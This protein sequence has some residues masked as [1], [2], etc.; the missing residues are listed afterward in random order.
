MEKQDIEELRER[1][2]CAAVLEAAGFALDLRESTR[3]ALKYRRGGEIVIVNHEGRGWFDPLSDAKG[4]VFSL[5]SH[6]DGGSFAQALDRIAEL[7]GF[8]P[9]TPHWR[10][11]AREAEI[12]AALPDRWRSRRKPWPGSA[13]WR[14]LQGERC[15]SDYVIRAAIRQDMLREG[16]HGSVWAA[17]TDDDGSIIGWEERGREWRGF[18][19]GG[20]KALFRIGAL[21]GLR[22]TIT[23]AAIDA[24]SLAALEGLREGSL[25]VST[26]GGWSPTTEVAIRRL[27]ARAGCRLVAATDAD[28]QG[29]AYAA[30]IREIAE[31]EG[32]DWLR[33]TPTASD[34]NQ[35][36]QDRKGKGNRGIGGGLPHVRRPRQGFAPPG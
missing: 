17:H 23:E 33:L 28:A 31:E 9:P 7:V 12:D 15:L 11:P 1:V 30:R 20:G 10:G 27:A 2:S 3:R 6:L 29:E 4:D 26:G 22:V 21:D 5:T 25:Y 8:V 13:T 36:M 24:M 14:Y 34:W 19:T 16:P 35:M 32:C 18:S